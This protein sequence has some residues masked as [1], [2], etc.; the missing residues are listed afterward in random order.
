MLTRADQDG[1]V[2]PATPLGGGGLRN[3]L[4]RLAVRLVTTYCVWKYRYL[5]RRRVEFGPGF[6]CNWRLKIRGPGRVI[7]GEGVNAW[8][9]AEPNVFIT[10]RPESEI[11]VGPNT[12]LNGAGLMAARGIEIGANCILGS[13]VLLDTDFHSVDVDRRVN[14]DAHV[15]TR[16]IRLANNVW[17]GGQAAILKGVQVGENSVI[18]FRAVVIDDVPPNVVVA[19]NPARIVRRL[20]GAPLTPDETSAG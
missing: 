3:A 14:P 8:A 20:D 7:I 6:I 15:R 18:G 9:H 19:G 2:A 1:T 11:R 4:V 17:V 16:P 5:W 13:A 12:R 10:Y